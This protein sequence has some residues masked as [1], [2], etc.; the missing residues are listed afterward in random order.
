[1]EKARKEVENCQEGCKRQSEELKFNESE[2][3]RIRQNY[4]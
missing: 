1:M 3:D 4:K 2:L